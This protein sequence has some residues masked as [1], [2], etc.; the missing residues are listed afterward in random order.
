MQKNAKQSKLT[1][2]HIPFPHSFP[3]QVMNIVGCN[4][5]L[6]LVYFFIY[7][8]MNMISEYYNNTGDI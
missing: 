3:I 5:L 7:Y 8:F 2:A 6:F 1:L 4:D